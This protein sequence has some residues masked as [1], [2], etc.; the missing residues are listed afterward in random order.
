MYVIGDGRTNMVSQTPKPNVKL[1][2]HLD[3]DR[4]YDWH[5]SEEYLKLVDEMEHNYYVD[6]EASYSNDNYDSGYIDFTVTFNNSSMGNVLSSSFFNNGF[7]I[8]LEFPPSKCMVEHRVI[9]ESVYCVLNYG[10]DG[11][12]TVTSD[13]EETYTVNTLNTIQ[14]T[15]VED[16]DVDSRI[17]FEADGD[18][19][20]INPY[21]NVGVV[22]G[23]PI[24]TDDPYKFAE[25]QTYGGNTVVVTLH[26]VP[27]KVGDCSFKV[28]VNEELIPTVFNF[29]VVGNDEDNSGMIA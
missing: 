25:V 8:S 4:T 16:T 22:N 21:N 24:S 12:M 5:D 2:S 19:L 28:T 29:T 10:T 20:Y 26:F 23:H 11:G 9:F 17:S 18:G 13:N 15:I 14:F 3:P 27:T 7:G 6:A 1:W